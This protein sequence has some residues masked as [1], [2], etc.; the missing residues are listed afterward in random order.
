MISLDIFSPHKK[1]DFENTPMICF[2]H[3]S[4]PKTIYNIA[5]EKWH[6]TSKVVF[7]ASIFS[8]TLVFGT[9]IDR[10]RNC[11]N[12]ADQLK[13]LHNHGCPFVGLPKKHP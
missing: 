7:Q 9:K 10:F 3:K 4:L 2:V 5:P 8:A 13:E 12:F 1:G 6:S 11:W